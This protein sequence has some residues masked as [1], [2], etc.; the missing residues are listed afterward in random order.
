MVWQAWLP[1]LVRMADTA[2]RI[3]PVSPQHTTKLKRQVQDS[4]ASAWP[5][6]S[7]MAVL[8]TVVSSSR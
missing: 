4:A 3:L 1:L 7:L 8:R 6:L 2:C 5:V